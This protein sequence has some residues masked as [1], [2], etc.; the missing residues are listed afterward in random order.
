MKF[1]PVK[2]DYTYV[3]ERSKTGFTE[4]S[5]NIKLQKMKHEEMLVS[6]EVDNILM[7]SK[8]DLRQIQLMSWSKNF[9][10]LEKDS[11]MDDILAIVRNRETRRIEAI[12]SML[13]NLN[14]STGKKQ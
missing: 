14:F 6:V 5:L 1:S 9:H 2:I 10:D 8:E 11:T 7:N 4:G 13:Q 3:M 12:Q